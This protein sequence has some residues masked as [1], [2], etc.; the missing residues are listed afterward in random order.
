[1]IYTW[2]TQD[3]LDGYKKLIKLYP[4]IHW[5]IENGFR[6]TTLQRIEKTNELICLMVDDDV[7]YRKTKLN[8]TI[9]ND[10]LN[11]VS[12]SV[13]SFRLGTNITV[14]DNFSN[15]PVQQPQFQNIAYEGQDTALVWKNENYHSP[16]HYSVSLDSHVFRKEWLLKRGQEINFETPNFLEGNLQKFGREFSNIVSPIESNLTSIPMNRV[17]DTFTNKTIGD[18]SAEELNKKWLDGYQIDLESLMKNN[19]NCTHSNWSYN[20]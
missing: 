16:F 19:C 1:M 20:V 18:I 6:N 4:D 14:G 5:E 12:D 17:Q 13:F 11:H 15:Q 9:I 3:F 7:F 10:I 2:S 8:I